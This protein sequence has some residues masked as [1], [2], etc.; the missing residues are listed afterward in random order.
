MAC[1]SQVIGYAYA[2]SFRD[3]E[4]YQFTVETTVYVESD[5]QRQGVGYE[6]MQHLLLRLSK[7]GYHAAVAG[8]SLPNP[9]SIA[10]HE[11]LGFRRAGVLPQVGRKFDAWHDIGFWILNLPKY[12]S[13]G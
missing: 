5:F 4:A 11:Q 10:L 2:S 3:R 8:I 1:D 9:G 13:K 12:K 7:L 6:L